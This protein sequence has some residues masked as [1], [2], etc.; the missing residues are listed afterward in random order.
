MRATRCSISRHECSAHIAAIT[1][2]TCGSRR[3][4]HPTPTRDTSCI[5]RRIAVP[6]CCH[7]P[8]SNLSTAHEREVRRRNARRE[9]SRDAG[10]QRG[11]YWTCRPNRPLGHRRQLHRRNGRGGSSGN[12][13]QNSTSDIVAATAPFM[14]KPPAR[15]AGRTATSRVRGGT[16]HDTRQPAAPLVRTFT[17]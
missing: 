4:H 10:R 1:N 14:M 8:S 11:G 7:S 12:N 3:T 2:S 17:K 5:A 9:T 6:L 13:G 16:S 15:T